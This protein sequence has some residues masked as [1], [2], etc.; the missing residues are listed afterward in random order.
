M[1]HILERLESNVRSYSRSFP[2]VFSKAKGSYLYD[3]NGT[4]YLDFFAG[5]GAL[6]YG[7]NNELLK[8]A[9]I[10]LILQDHVTHSL[11]M[12]TD[13]KIRFVE[14]LEEKLLAPR[15][16]DHKIQFCG[17]TGTNAVEAALKL[18]RKATQRSTIAYFTNSFH[19][20][21]MG[22]LSIGGNPALRNSAQIPFRYTEA[23]PFDGCTSEG[24][25][26]IAY[27]RSRINSMEQEGNLP[28]AFILEGVQAEGGVNVAS[29]SWL[30]S[31]AQLAQEKGILLIMDEIQVG[32]GRTG[33]F[34]SF[35]PYGV[36]PDLITV[37]KS[38]S[39]YGIP[40]AALFI[41][42]D[43]DIWS[44]GEHNGTFRGYNPG[45][46]TATKA[47]EFWEDDSLT[48]STL[49][50]EERIRE[51]FNSP[52]LEGIIQEVR[53]RGMMIGL[54]FN[55]GISSQAIAKDCYENGLIIETCGR[56]SSVLK[57]LPPLTLSPNELEKGLSI[58]GTACLK[59]AR[60]IKKGALK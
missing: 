49:A 18:A 2:S 8:T 22:S 24:V 57:L 27:I 7:H 35:E 58:I 31:L 3:S 45:F 6:N 1:K 17:P 46:A 51:Y 33:T 28:A 44:P 42:P 55:E 50:K 14:A 52:S 19:G 60:T 39:G 25:D 16:L 11:D 4:A 56:G 47:L 20:V 9:L 21:T 30:K 36:I 40:L 48:Q 26:S 32:C 13:A 54:T 12:A 59:Q 43:L 10:D 41:R 23:F 5:A 53:G 37:S 34:F 29:G 15:K 38:L